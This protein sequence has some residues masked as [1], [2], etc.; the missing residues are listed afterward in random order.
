MKLVVPNILPKP[1][2]SLIMFAFQAVLDFNTALF[3]NVRA[4]IATQEPLVIAIDV[5][6]ILQ[7]SS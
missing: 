1:T 6:P 4:R 3:V 5:G 7:T 2:P